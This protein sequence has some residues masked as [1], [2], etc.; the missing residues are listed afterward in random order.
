MQIELRWLNLGLATTLIAI[1]T[2]CSSPTTA[3]RV[4]NCPSEQPIKNSAQTASPP[5]NALKAQYRQQDW[6]QLPDWP[7]EGLSTSFLAWRSSCGKAKQAAALQPLC[8]AAAHVPNEP[9]AIQHFLETHF[10][11]W[12][13]FNPDGSSNGLITGY[14]EPV[15]RGSLTR[16]SG[17][18][19]PVYG[20]PR[21][22]IT[23]EL[24]DIF[25]E[26]KG[27]RVRGRLVGQKLLPY[28]DRAEIVRK[29][30]DAPIIAWLTNP[31]DL[32]FMQV[33]G[34]GRIQL[35]NGEEIRLGYAD[36]NGRPYQPIGRWLLQQGA[37]PAGGVNM[38]A[39]RAW[40]QNHP[41]Q[42]ETLLNSNPSY[43]FFRILPS[44]QD[45]PLGAMGIPLTP[46]SSIAVDPSAIPLGSMVFLT[47][48]R[49]D[50]GHP[51]R[52]LV[53]AQ[54]TGGAIKG[55]VRADYFWGTGDQPGELAGRMQQ[56]G[57]L[58]LLWPR[59]S[60]PAPN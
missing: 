34:S 12:Q 1:I 36:Q 56:Q 6:T 26:L 46:Q 16:N 18:T 25:P 49:P 59:G 51:I 55:A 20:P 22:L 48:T 47:T 43:V 28:P 5:A 50:N 9:K 13:L 23:V 8:Q 27:R 39:I 3:P 42:I 10:T 14:Y 60:T 44:S 31:I 58:W 7:G 57:G 35:S 4:N 11:P 29:G 32:Q 15:Y 24:S 53:A 17:A 54:D 30:V 38:Q 41:E 52:R 45:G 37:L 33:Q 2:A 21:D 19:I 40:A